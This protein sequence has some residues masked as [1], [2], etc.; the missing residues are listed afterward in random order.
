MRN[1]MR[2]TVSTFGALAGLAGL[3]HGIGEVLQGNTAPERMII[4]SW[5][6]SEW[7]AILAGEPA[8]TLVPSLFMTGILAI[9]VSLIFLAW[10]AMFAQRKHGGLVLILLSG[11]MLIVGGGFGP[12]ILGVIVGIAATG[13]N[14]PLMWWRMR[15][16]EGLR[17]F[18]AK[19]WPWSYVAGIIA[20]LLVMP[21]T[22]LLDYFFSVSDLD[23]I[24]S[25]LAL[26]VLSAF[27]LLLVTVF[28][29]FAYDVQRQIGLHKTNS[30][31]G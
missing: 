26:T 25:I 11:L 14:A 22:I 17:C 15:L 2:I 23:F 4:L 5:P 3:E 8:M 9:L 16:S 10:A 19:V 6:E 21:G 24:V 1:A 12:P 27:G 18:L 29:A 7:F 28:A 30:I 20:W 31:N 13:I